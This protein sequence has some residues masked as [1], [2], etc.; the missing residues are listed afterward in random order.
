[1]NIIDLSDAFAHYEEYY[2]QDVNYREAGKMVSD[3]LLEHDAYKSDK[4][5]ETICSLFES[6]GDMLE[7]D[8]TMDMLKDWAK[9]NHCE[10]FKGVRN[11]W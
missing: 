6:V 9:N 5:Y 11:G 2:P 1:M 3:I 7:F 8:T 10:I 4:D